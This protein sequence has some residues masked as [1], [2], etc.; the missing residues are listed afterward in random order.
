MYVLQK[1]FNFEASHQLLHH[2]G[3][4][5]G[6]HG[7]SYTV[8]LELSGPSVQKRGPGT[9]MLCDFTHISAAVKPLVQKYLDHHHLNDSLDTDSP[10]AEFIAR[11]IFERMLP[12]LPLLVAVTVKET[13]SS[14][15]IY[16]PRR[17]QRQCDCQCHENYGTSTLTMAVNGNSDST[18]DSLETDR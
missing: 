18:S 14:V 2:D 10:T 6:L 7:H 13:A 11:W 12:K 5:A 1:T 3:K 8:V 4:C 17:T 15:A 16:R 9:N